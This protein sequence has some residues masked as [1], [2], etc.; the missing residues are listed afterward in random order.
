MPNAQRPPL[1]GDLRPGMIAPRRRPV[2]PL[3]D[4]IEA[5]EEAEREFAEGKTISLDDLQRQLRLPVR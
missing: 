1:A 4:E 5:I 2:W 3:P